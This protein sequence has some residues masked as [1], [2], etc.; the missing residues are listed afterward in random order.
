MKVAQHHDHAL[1]DDPRLTGIKQHSLDNRLV[2][3][4]NDPRVHP[5]LDQGLAQSAQAHPGIHQIVEH[6]GPVIVVAGQWTAEVVEEVHFFQWDAISRDDNVRGL[7]ELDLQRSSFAQVLALA[8][9]AV[10]LGWKSVQGLVADV[11]LAFGAAFQWLA[12]LFRNDDGYPG[13]DGG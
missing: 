10:E 11:H 9:T 6:G 8:H 3:K 1:S 13:G 2:K 12:S 5:R 7:M 4:T